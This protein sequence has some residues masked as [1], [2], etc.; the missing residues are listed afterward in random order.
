LEVLCL[1]HETEFVNRFS[2]IRTCARVLSA[3]MA[4]LI[5]FVGLTTLTAAAI[6]G[7]VAA[8]T[9]TA[10][11]VALVIHVVGSAIVI[12]ATLAALGPDGG[13]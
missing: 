5:I 6:G 11:V 7:A 1:F 9:T 8:G 12:G 4:L 10:V 2:R 13:D 3:A